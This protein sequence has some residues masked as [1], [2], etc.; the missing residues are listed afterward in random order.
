MTG[1]HF[2]A[3]PHAFPR[4]PRAQKSESI[5]VALSVPASVFWIFEFEFVNDTQQSRC[6]SK[7]LA[8]GLVRRTFSSIY[9]SQMLHSTHAETGAGPHRPRPSHVISS[10]SLSFP[11]SFPVPHS[12]R[13]LPLFLSLPSL[14]VTLY[15]RLSSSFP[16]LPSVPRLSRLF[17]GSCHF[18]LVA[19][20]FS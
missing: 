9:P 19:S 1:F 7:S 14:P 13:R 8:S 10:F 5:A 11:L 18:L 12:A 20:D 3:R 16:A 17:A 4:H 15:L 2:S 6:K